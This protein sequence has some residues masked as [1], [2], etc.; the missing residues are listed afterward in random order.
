[1]KIDQ[2]IF[3]EYDIRGKYP[4]QLNE[5]TAYALGLAFARLNKYKKVIIGR[6]N[7]VESENFFWPLLAGLTAGNVQVYDVGVCATPELF[8]AIGK[9]NNIYGA[10]VTASHS[11]QGETGVKFCDNRGVVFGLNTGLKKIKS[12]T[13]KKAIKLKK[14]KNKFIINH[15]RVKFCSFARDYR[16]FV[17]SFVKPTK[18]EGLKIILDAS[19]GSGGRL[20]ETVFSSLPIKTTYMNFRPNDNFI[21][22]NLNPLLSESQKPIGKEI[23][24]RKA[25]LGIIFDG[26]ADR[27]IFVDEKGKFIEPYYINCLLSEIILTTYKEIEIVIDGRLSLLLPKLIKSKGG[28][29]LRHRAGYANI[30]KTMSENKLLFGCE[31]SG[32]FMFNFL[33]KEKKNFAYGDAIIPILLVMEFLN[34]KKIKLSQAVEKYHKLSAIS[35][36]LNFKTADFDKIVKNIK[37]Y[38]SDSLF[39]NLDGLSVWSKAGYWFFNLRPSHTEPLIRLNIEADDMK[40]VKELKRKL[41]QL[42]KI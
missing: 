36:E 15:E 24:K 2:K 32:H 1:M 30:I 29:V 39:D 19:N 5:A 27:A 33:L 12:L 8:F 17:L 11:P 3:K 9:K 4:E 35:G 38:Y 18:L 20:A 22:H 13:E 6:D 7:R 26:D 25:D 41:V 34:R 14:Q 37:D 28:R 40:K 23:K 10:M 42:I 21:D 16:D 31:N